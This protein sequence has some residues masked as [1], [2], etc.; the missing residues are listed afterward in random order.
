MD[1]E[2]GQTTDDKELDIVKTT[3]KT[4]FDEFKMTV[5]IG[6]L[7]ILNADADRLQR[8]LEECAVLYTREQEAL[9]EV[10]AQDPWT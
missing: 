8:I 7:E 3:Y 10:N 5:D 1:P 2:T 4:K 9:G 6:Y